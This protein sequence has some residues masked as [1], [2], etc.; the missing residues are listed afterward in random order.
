M[1]AAPDHKHIHTVVFGGGQE[2]G[3][4]GFTGNDMWAAKIISL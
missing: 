4:V 2:R 1:T 3:T